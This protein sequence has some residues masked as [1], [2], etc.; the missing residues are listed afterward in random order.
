M[1]SKALRIDHNGSATLNIGNWGN[2]Q[3]PLVVSVWGDFE[4]KTIGAGAGQE[5]K[6][7]APKFCL[8]ASCIT[9]WPDGSGGGTGDIGAVVAGSGLTAPRF[10]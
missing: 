8:G 9:S 1:D 3:Q 6:I 10:R 5:G 7:S 2:G 4:T